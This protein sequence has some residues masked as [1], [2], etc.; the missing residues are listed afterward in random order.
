MVLLM[1]LAIGYG[2]LGIW[3]YCFFQQAYGSWHTGRAGAL[4]SQR[5]MGYQD[6]FRFFVII[7]SLPMGPGFVGPARALGWAGLGPLDWAQLW[8][9]LGRV[10]PGGAQPG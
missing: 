10:G 4:G 2:V 1:F 5:I 9:G 3:F 7:T 6:G 8:M